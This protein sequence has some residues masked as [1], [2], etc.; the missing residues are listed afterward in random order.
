MDWENRLKAL[1]ET[2]PK[3]ATQYATAN[4]EAVRSV[5]AG[6][7]PDSAKVGSH[8]GARMVCN[9]AS[10]HI[11]AFVQASLNGEDRPYKNGYDL[12]KF[13][14]G[15]P[16]PGE[17]LKTREKVDRALPV[18][19]G[20]APDN[21]YFGAVEINGAG[22]RFYGDVCLVLKEGVVA[23]ETTILDRN[24][25]DLVRSPIRERIEAPSAGM[26]PEEALQAEAKEMAGNWGQDLSPIAAIKVLTAITRRDRRF[27]TGAI[28]DGV[29]SDEDYIE[30]LRCGSFRTDQLQEARHNAADAA[31]DALLSDRWRVGPCPSH[32]SLVWQEQRRRAEEFLRCANVT[33]RIV[34]TSGR[35][36]S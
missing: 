35:V 13:R 4:V 11:P 18:P 8:A 5:V 2:F 1:L 22:I 10:A 32:E 24:S 27:T 36:R 33:V 34:T 3:E 25:Y 21:I 6:K 16:P 12:K 30:I 15:D 19:P 28:S 9:I 31:Q 17:V 29:L 23:Q 7:G 20:N 26:T 14:V